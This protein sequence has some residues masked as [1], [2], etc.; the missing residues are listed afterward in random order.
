MTKTEANEIV[1]KLIAAA[2]KAQY[3]VT[4]ANSCNTPSDHRLADAAEAALD[5][6]IDAA[7]DAMV[8]A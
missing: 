5:D 4:V 6:A 3:R 8:R 7:V 2:R 1:Q